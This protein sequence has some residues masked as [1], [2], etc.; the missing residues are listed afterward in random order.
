MYSRFAPATIKSIQDQTGANIQVPKH[1]DPSNPS[2]RTLQISHVNEAGA[3]QAQERILS[4]LNSRQGSTDTVT[5]HVPIP[6]SDVGLCIG[7]QGS[8][9]QYM[10]NASGARIQIPPAGHPGETHRTC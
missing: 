9:I 4:I 3:R 1:G 7:R 5:I 2:I 10:Q 8:V 6:N